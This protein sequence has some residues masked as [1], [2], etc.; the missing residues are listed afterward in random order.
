MLLG[1]NDPENIQ[2]RGKSEPEWMRKPLFSHFYTRGIGDDSRLKT[3]AHALAAQEDVAI[4][5]AGGITN[6]EAGI[7]VTRALIRRLASI[8]TIAEDSFD[9]DKPMHVYG[10]DSL[11]AV[12]LR[13]WI[14]REIRTDLAIFDIM[15]SAS[16]RAI[17]IMIAARSKYR[18]G[19]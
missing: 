8:L 1:I 5:L 2:K 13:N 10:V 4:L 3:N 16:L 14:A 11:I 12:D 19:K 15:G 18:Q 6:K 17:G 7:V 9:E